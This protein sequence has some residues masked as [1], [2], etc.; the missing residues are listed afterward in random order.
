MSSK[1]LIAFIRYRRNGT[2]TGAAA[3]MAGIGLIEA[4]MHDASLAAGEYD[5][6]ITE[7]PKEELQMASDDNI[8]AALAV[9]LNADAQVER[10]KRGRPPKSQSAPMPAPV[11]GEIVD[12]D[13]LGI[14]E[15]AVVSGGETIPI[16]AKDFLD[17][18][19]ASISLDMIVG[20]A[21]AGANIHGIGPDEATGPNP[22]YVP[23]P[24]TH[25][26]GHEANLDHLASLADDYIADPSALLGSFR[27]VVLAL[28]RD[29]RMPW[30]GMSPEEQRD[31]V[32]TIEY[33]GR[34]I[35]AEMVRA[36]AAKNRPSIPAHFKKLGSDGA[37]MTLTLEVST[38]TTTRDDQ[39]A[40]HDSLRQDVVIVP[41]DWSAYDR[42]KREVVPTDEP[43]LAFDAPKPEPTRAEVMGFDPNP[44]A[45]PADDSD[46][47]GDDGIV[48][49]IP[50]A[51]VPADE[52]ATWVVQ[53]TDGDEIVWL[54]VSEDA[55]TENR[56]LAGRFT[57]QRA[58]DLA[59]EHAAKAVE[60]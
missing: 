33:S 58:D 56:E 23:E 46:L 11:N 54:H 27:D 4:A 39:N 29:R 37:K 10:K 21:N 13:P 49:D 44:P 28:F 34:Q 38:A 50:P 48:E 42:V 31:T 5:D 59:F 16:E 51:A 7:S 32:R 60:I 3:H 35:I 14:G 15:E 17:G 40:L 43:E 57:K 22:D 55:W 25:H 24:E 53:D 6:I 45:H 8:F 9:E 20:M 1:Q 52:T 2:P 12:D 30:H 19:P 36:V 41:A 47:A 26:G 18:E